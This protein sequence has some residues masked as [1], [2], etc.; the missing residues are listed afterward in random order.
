[1]CEPTY[2]SAV[3]TVLSE[4]FGVAPMVSSDDLELVERPVRSIML[5][6]DGVLAIPVVGGLYHRGDALNAMSGSMSYT[7]LNNQIVSALADDEVK[8]ILLDIDSPGGAVG[9]AFEAADMVRKASAIK[10][11][12]AIANT[13]AASAAYAI[14]SGAEKIFATPS[15][16]VGSIGVITMHIDQSVAMD[17][18][19]LKPTIIH[20]GK[21]KKQGNSLEPLS[22]GDVA[23]IQASIDSVYEMFVELVASMRPMSAD[24]IRATEARVYD[25][26]AAVDLGLVDG[27]ATF[28][29]VRGSLSSRVNPRF[30]V[31]VTPTGQ[32]LQLKEPKA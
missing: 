32:V 25:A 7:Y 26:R 22:E 2:A 9:G 14:A 16:R 17:R 23:D 11:I 27:V 13:L 6:A 12:Y 31:R 20:S 1:M 28:E 4:R 19:G 21:Y 10:P 8:A 24:A 29:D 3:A 5:D 15:A 30:S 18:R